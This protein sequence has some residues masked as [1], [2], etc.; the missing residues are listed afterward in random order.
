VSASGITL[1]LAYHLRRHFWLGWSLARWLGLLLVVAIIWA[2]LPWQAAPWPAAVP[3]VLFLI[4][5][6]VQ[7][8]ASRQRFVRFKAIPGLDN[9]HSDRPSPQPLGVQEMVP[10]RASG[11]FTVEGQ[12]QYYI[13][14]E[15]DYETVGTREH[16]VLGRVRPSRFLLLGRWP[17]LEL[18]WWYIFFQPGMI[19][20]MCLGHLHFGARPYLALRV[21]YAP[22][23]ETRQ[24]VYLTFADPM[25]L[26]RVWDD[27]RLDAPAGATP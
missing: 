3:A 5:V 13:D 18:G 27:L 20:D 4:Y 16:I 10:V 21:I 2:L 11:W 9:P 8:W 23:E 6:L 15:A 22:V 25:A 26:R 1:Q 24:T 19:R 12:D 7:T 17:S 14:L